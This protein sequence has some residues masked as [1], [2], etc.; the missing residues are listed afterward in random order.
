V[1]PG[2][3]WARRG[4]VREVGR[5]RPRAG[6]TSAWEREGG[7]WAEI[8]PTGGRVIPFSFS[9]SKSISLSPFL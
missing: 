9:I 5:A 1:G 6:E 4:R 2:W 3:Q 8:G 7:A